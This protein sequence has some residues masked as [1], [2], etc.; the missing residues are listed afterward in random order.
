MKRTDT[1]GLGALVLLAWVATGQAGYIDHN[2]D[3]S[4]FTNGATFVTQ[5][6]QW[7]ASTDSVVVVTGNAWSAPHSILVP[8]GSA[9]SNVV[10]ETSPSVVWTDVRVAPYLG[11]EP[12]ASATNG[13]AVVQYFGTNGYLNVW[14]NGG[15]LACS[16][17][18]WGQTVAKVTNGV[19][20]DVS[21]CQNFSN[22]TVAILLN[23]QVVIQDL[24]F[25]GAFTNYGSFRMTGAS[26]DAWL[27]DAYITNTYATARLTNNL[28]GIDGA[29]A[30]ELQTYGYVARTLY[31]GP[32]SGC[33]GFPT[34]QAALNAW[35]A[36]DLFYVYGGQYAEAVTVTNSVTFGGQPFTNS[37]TL[38]IKAGASPGFPNGMAWGSVTIDTNAACIFSQSLSCSNLVVRSGATVTFQAVTCSNLIVET[39]ARLTCL[40]AFACANGC[41]FDQTASAGFSNTVSCSGSV[42]IASSAAVTLGQ[43]AT[44]GALACTGSVILG[45]GTSLTVDSAVV[46]G[47]VYVTGGATATVT[48]A[49]NL[50][51]GGHMDF[52]QSRFLYAPLSV[53]LFGTF[54]ISNNWGVGGVVGVS[55]NA[56]CRFDQALVCSNLTVASGAT[57]TLNQ[58]ATLTS[59]NASGTVLVGA[60]N[61]LTVTTATVSGSGH[62]DFSGGRFV[63][64]SSGVDMTGTFSVTNSWGTQATVGLDFIDDFELYAPDTEVANLGFRGW[65]ASST[66]V[67]VKAVLGVG[68]SKGVMVPESSALSNR[69][70]SAGQPKI[71]TDFSVKPVPGEAPTSVNTNSYTFLSYVGT[72]GLLN[73]WNSGAWVVCSNYVDGSAVPA[74]DTG[75]YTRVTVF[76]NFGTHR[77]AVFVGGKIVRQQLPFPS[78][79]A[80]SSYSSFRAQSPKGSAYLDNTRITAGIA[81]GLTADLDND[82]MPDAAEIQAYDS[83]FVWTGAPGSIFRFR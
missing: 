70:A 63:V 55:A 67:L 47:A 10:G 52:I 82:W 17:D 77:A 40:G 19:F 16:N 76:L 18:V 21:I 46:P 4:P 79:A 8:K 48:T 83:L 45:A 28:N 37:G 23:D 31:F 43:G 39:G 12:P 50:P 44:F 80:I 34:M 72:N 51:V 24:P 64:S 53:N 13:V 78:G 59:L 1:I 30:A 15:W 27:D 81:T 71:W 41:S 42:S 62:L 38:T 29:D 69:V 57:V 68:S 2:F 20:A 26:G 61:T 3:T 11:E 35:R 7:R 66:G 32:G 36:R 33:P 60:G 75:S 9:L 58:G 14:T 6:L 74:M 22:Q 25:L 56:Q 73:V 49:L 65:G 54:S 5:V